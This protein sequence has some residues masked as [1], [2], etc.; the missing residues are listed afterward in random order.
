[1]S[2]STHSV[3]AQDLGDEKTAY[4][5]FEGACRVDLGEEMRSSDMG[6]HSASMGGIWQCAVYGFGGVRIV[7][8]EL[9]IAPKLPK[10]W[11]HL[12]FSVVWHGCEL[13]V[14]ATTNQ[15]AVCNR[16]NTPAIIRLN[17]AIT[18]IS[19]GQTITVAAEKQS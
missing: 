18:E 4:S 17:G 14:D 19:A 2:K 12:T 7:G 5:L 8:N 13:A 16:G 10:A 1:M 3:L 6:I 9:H 11:S 15:T